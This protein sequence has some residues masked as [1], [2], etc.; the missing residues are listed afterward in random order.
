[1]NLYELRENFVTNLYNTQAIVHCRRS[2][3]QMEL[4][5]NVIAIGSLN[6]RR[7]N[8]EWIRYAVKHMKI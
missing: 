1:M 4:Y 6:K 7:T 2:K 3:K 5:K 8:I